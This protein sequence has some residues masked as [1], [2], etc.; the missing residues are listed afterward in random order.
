MAQAVAEKKTSAAPASGDGAGSGSGGGLLT[1]H[2]PGEGTMTRLGS[3]VVAFFFVVF[4]AFHWYYGWIFVRNLG[5][6]TLGFIGLDGLLS[7]SRSPTASY[8]IS[9]GGAVVVA[10]VGLLLAYYVVF[11]QQRTAE[12]LVQTDGELRK[13]TWPKITPWFKAETQVWGITYVI[14][15]TTAALAL[16]IASVDKILQILANWLFYG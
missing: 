12:F 7:W 16:F 3:F 4:T 14:L 15:I 5:Q 8:Y 13:V 11:C 6:K 10:V 1:V 2:K 9:N